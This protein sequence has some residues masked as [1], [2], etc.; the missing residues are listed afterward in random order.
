MKR[1]SILALL[2]AIACIMVATLSCS[3]DDEVDIAEKM[4]IGKWKLEKIGISTWT[5]KEKTM[6]FQKD[7]TVTCCSELLN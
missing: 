3:K 7:G 4:I 2:M 6:L 1:L 5:G